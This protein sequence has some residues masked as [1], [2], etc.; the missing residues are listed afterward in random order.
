MELKYA[1]KYLKEQDS[2]VTL[3]VKHPRKRKGCDG[4]NQDTP[5]EKFLGYCGNELWICNDCFERLTAWSF[6]E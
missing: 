5:T 4:C 3:K 1:K 2:R 6:T